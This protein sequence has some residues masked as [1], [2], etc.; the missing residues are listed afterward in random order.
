MSATGDTR[1]TFEALR[2]AAGAFFGFLPFLGHLLIS[3]F[4]GGRFRRRLA[5]LLAVRTPVPVD[6][7]SGPGTCRKVYVLAGEESGDLHAA[8]LVRALLAADPTIAVRGMG[9]PRLLAAGVHLDH[10][11]VSM[12]VMGVLP[13]LRSVGTWFRLFKELLRIFDEDPPDVFVPVDYPGLNLR[14][15]RAA[16][17]R[18]I[19]VVAYIAPQIWAWAPWRVRHI[20]R[21]VDR[22]LAILPFEREMFSHA[23]LPTAFVGHP[24]FEHL[25]GTVPA[26]PDGGPR[27]PAVLGLLPGSRRAEVRHLLPAMLRAA[28]EVCS[29]RP[30]LSVVLPCRGA[31]VRAEV[32]RVLARDGE[33]L[34]V[35]VAEGRTHEEMRDMDLAL[36][37]S[38]TASLELAYYGVPMVVMYR[39]SRLGALLKRILLIT[40]HVALVNIVAGR[41]IAPELVKAGDLAAP[42]A[43]ALRVWLES[44]SERA[45]T[46]EALRGVRERLLVAG[47]SRRAAGFVSSAGSPAGTPRG[48]SRPPASAPGPRTV[49]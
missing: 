6:E 44:A 15:A 10:D 28:R 25:E 23:R 3:L 41:K 2:V 4:F 9:G 16:R 30:G 49:S 18:G 5:S 20:A 34:P 33:G 22:M 17:K 47:A 38:G 13:V 45:T 24:L 35:R 8:N 32:D 21:C 19:R 1:R 43:R 48:G 26:P 39:I 27:E 37:A 31:R 7:P 42:A 11:L 14:V 29:G 46:R 40:P 36:V 12:S